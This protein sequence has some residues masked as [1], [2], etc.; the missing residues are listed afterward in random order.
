MTKP[1]QTWREKWLAMEDGCSSD[2][3]SDKEAIKVSSARG[4][5][6]SE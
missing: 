4:E 5:D 1:E 2:D 3:S 6:N